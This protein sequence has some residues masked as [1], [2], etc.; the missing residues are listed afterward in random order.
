[1]RVRRPEDR[2]RGWEGTRER[3]MEVRRWEDTELEDGLVRWGEPVR[4]MV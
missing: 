4:R 3:R 1:M 2:T